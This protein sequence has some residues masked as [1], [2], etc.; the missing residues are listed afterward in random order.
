MTYDVV[1]NDDADQCQ[2]QTDANGVGPQGG[3]G[4][5]P[6]NVRRRMSLRPGSTG[7]SGRNPRKQLGGPA[8]GPGG[9][10]PAAA[11]VQLLSLPQLDGM[12]RT[13]KLLDVRMQHVQANA[14][15]DEK[16]STCVGSWFITR[17]RS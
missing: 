1:D 7:R 6:Y 15:Q 13:L 4:G 16:V 12:Q 2:G 17:S 8:G 10:G 9:C 14:K 11:A 3:D 5:G